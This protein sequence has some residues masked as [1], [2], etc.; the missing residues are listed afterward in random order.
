MDHEEPV[1]ANLY[2]LYCEYIHHINQSSH[3]RQSDARDLIVASKTDFLAVWNTLPK[4][5][6]NLWRRQFEAGY[7]EVARLDRRK[8]AAAFSCN[9]V[10]RINRSDIR[11]A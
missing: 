6:R 5:R 9:S 8:L 7:D 3:L 10:N 1:P 4:S 11:A 2:S